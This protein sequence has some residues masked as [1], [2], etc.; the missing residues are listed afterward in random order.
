MSGD[1]AVAAMGGAVVEERV[2]AALDLAGVRAWLVAHAVPG[3]DTIDPD[4]DGGTRHRR[5]VRSPEGGA[6]LEVVLPGSGGAVLRASGA[7]AAQALAVGRRWLGLDLDPEPAAATLAADPDL[8][9]LVRA[10]PLLRV[11]GAPDPFEAAANVVLG[12]HVSV[13]AGRL[14]A[15]RLA[16]VAGVDGGPAEAG[17]VAG[18]DPDDLQG[19]TGVT[20]AR[21]GT[22]V[23]LARAVVDGLDLGPSPDDDARAAT[24]AA[25]LALP[26]VGPWTADLVAMR[27][28]R[29]PDVFL[30][31]DLVLRRAMGGVT[32]AEAGRH[33]RAWAPH[34]SLA[35]V[36]L[37][38]HHA[39]DPAPVRT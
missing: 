9:P 7:G 23:A 25:L 6:V 12:Q 10:R 22:L 35:V 11:P 18:I 29:D 26:G 33:A 17:R 19:A 1:G 24:R 4:V 8:G 36:H 5:R 27:C 32:A 28:L 34:R 30:P 2:E 15:G 39:L 14:F 37:W 21:A 31:G 38:T 3:V 20:G 16:T 13:A